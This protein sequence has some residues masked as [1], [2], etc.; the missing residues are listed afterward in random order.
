MQQ[1]LYVV[2][3][4]AVK[5]EPSSSMAAATPLLF[6]GLAATATALVALVEAASQVRTVALFLGFEGTA[7]LAAVLLNS[8]L[9]PPADS[10]IWEWLFVPQKRNVA[11]ILKQPLF[12][13]ALIFLLFQEAL[14]RL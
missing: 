4:R 5:N 3:S 10:D 11:V 13:L 2:S 9:C 8:L 14:S 7:L 6:T 12:Y 1:T